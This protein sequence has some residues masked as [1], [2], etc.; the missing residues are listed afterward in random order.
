MV[1]TFGGATAAVIL[2][3]LAA[4]GAI[5][6]WRVRFGIAFVAAAAALWLLATVVGEPC[7]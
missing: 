1:G 5:L 7:P 3:G 6:G 2:L 4:P